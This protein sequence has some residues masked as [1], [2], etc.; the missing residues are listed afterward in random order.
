M[1]LD[2]PEPEVIGNPRRM[3]PHRSQTHPPGKSLHS[4][5]IPSQLGGERQRQNSVHVPFNPANYVK[6]TYKSVPMKN[7]AIALSWP[8]IDYDV[9]RHKGG[10][11]LYFDAAFDPNLQGYEVKLMRPGERSASI[12]TPEEIRMFVSPHTILQDMTLFHPKFPHWKVQVHNSRG[13]RCLDVFREIYRTFSAPLSQDELM[14]C[15]SRFIE[16]CEHAFNQRCED[17][18]GLPPVTKSKGICRIDLLKGERIF[19]GLVPGQKP[20][21][22]EIQFE[23]INRYR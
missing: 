22:W 2:T 20:Q 8:L 17:S 23:A 12:I 15:S 3:R 18:P 14:Q 7:E 10:P 19:R 9:R 5:Q 16:S 6:P 21:T 1:A 13:I 11:S 4:T